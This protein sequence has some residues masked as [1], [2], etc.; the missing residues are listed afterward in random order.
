MK[1]S[2]KIDILYLD[3]AGYVSLLHPVKRL[4]DYA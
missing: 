4:T 1:N 2:H 3:N